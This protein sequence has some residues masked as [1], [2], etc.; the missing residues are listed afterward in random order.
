MESNRVTTFLEPRGLQAILRKLKGSSKPYAVTGSLAAKRV[1]S[2]VEPRLA[3]IYVSDIGSSSIE[4]GLRPA[5]TGANIILAEPFDSVVL[6]RTIKANGVRYVAYS[7][8]AVDLLTG[9]GRNP[10]EGEELLAWMA[11]NE[12]KWRQPVNTF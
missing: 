1:A 9:P 6:D 10:A 4:L 8:L 5:E 11:R 2:I 3:V 12:T 7:Q